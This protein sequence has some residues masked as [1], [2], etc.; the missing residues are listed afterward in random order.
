MIRKV[1]GP[2]Q[3]REV[4][5]STVTPVERKKAVTFLC[6]PSS[7]RKLKLEKETPIKGKK[8]RQAHPVKGK[9]GR[10]QMVHKYNS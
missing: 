2:L 9:A 8:R 4:A 3:N 5:F 1:V 7:K 10:G 6:H